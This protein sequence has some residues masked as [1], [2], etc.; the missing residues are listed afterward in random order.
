MASDGEQRRCHCQRGH[1]RDKHPHRQGYTEALEVRQPS[2]MQTERRAG[3]R[4]PG[5]Q[6]HVRGAVIHRV[7]RGLAILTV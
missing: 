5:A 1:D 2:E 4:Q 7:K 3:D 6:D